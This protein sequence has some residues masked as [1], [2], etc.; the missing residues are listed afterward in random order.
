MSNHLQCLTFM[1]DLNYCYAF[2]TK[3]DLHSLFE[4]SEKD[5]YNILCQIYYRCY[6]IPLCILLIWIEQETKFCYSHNQEYTF[7]LY[8]KEGWDI[9]QFNSNATF[10]YSQK[11]LI[12]CMF[13]RLQI[14]YKKM[15][16]TSH[17]SILPISSSSLFLPSAGI[18][19]IRAIIRS[20]D[21]LLV[22]FMAPT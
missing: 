3:L 9:E 12:H 17:F 11:A 2:S 10:L 8:T 5:I 16:D 1:H 15:S 19:F 22:S 13:R 18:V 7:S 14:V 4:C 21:C 6:P 20:Y